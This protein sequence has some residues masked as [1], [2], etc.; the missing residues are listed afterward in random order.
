MENV[1]AIREFV[2]TLLVRKGDTQPF[3]NQTS[4]LLCGRLQS[5]DGVEIAVFLEKRFGL[6]FA[7]VGF[8]QERIDTVDEIVSLVDEFSQRR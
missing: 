8:D 4:L 5:V 7:S 3:S 1:T 6:D 2:R